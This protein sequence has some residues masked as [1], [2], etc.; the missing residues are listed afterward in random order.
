MS[1]KKDSNK[2]DSSQHTPMMRQYLAIKADYPDTLVF[3]RMGDFYELFYDDAKRAAKLIDIVLTARGKS[4]GEPIPMAGVP[5]HAVENYLGRLV[6]QGESVAICEQIG[7][8]ATSKGPV[9]RKVVRIVTP[10]TVT[11]EALLDERQE[12]LLAATCEFHNRIGLAWLELSSGRFTVMELK[13]S[14]SLL[15]ELER[16]RPAEL[17]VPENSDLY[18]RL[19]DQRGVT[20]RPPW[21]FDAESGERLLCKQFGTRDLAGFGCQAMPQSVAAAGSLMQYVADTQ[22]SALPHLQGLRVERRDDA[23]IMDAATRRNLELQ[24]SLVQ[25]NELTLAGVLDRAATAMG[26]RL[27]RRWI[28]R[29]LRNQQTLRHRYH[30]IA[31]LLAGSAHDT[32]HEALRGIGGI[33]RILARVALGSARPRDLT[34]LREALGRLPALAGLTA[35]L[36]SP[37]LEY[38]RQGAGEQPEIHALLCRAI[39]ESPPVLIRDGGVSLMAR[40]SSA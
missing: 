19:A 39:K 8:P 40:H 34:A 9:E 5:F 18:R 33:E 29:P 11:D 36:D 21:H 7:D 35:P 1:K 10:G 32:L 4:G 26:S 13:D 3:Y 30:A 20:E 17:L 6:R 28:S 24:H 16:L 15:A 31:T 37:L 12:N 27:L 2:K 14:A 23:L 25:R 22:R 38:L